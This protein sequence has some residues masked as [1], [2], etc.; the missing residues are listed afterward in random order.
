MHFWFQNN[1]PVAAHL[2]LEGDA[3]APEM[4]PGATGLPKDRQRLGSGRLG[5]M[6]SGEGIP[7]A[8]RLLRQTEHDLDPR[9]VYIRIRAAIRHEPLRVQGMRRRTT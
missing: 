2:V 6:Q 3:G 1:D 8:A 7:R 5:R 4:T 9:A